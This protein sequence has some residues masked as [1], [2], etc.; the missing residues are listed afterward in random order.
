MYGEHVWEMVQ[1]N[2]T[3]TLDDF[4]RLLELTKKRNE[5]YLISWEYSLDYQEII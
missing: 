3:F 1:Q 4:I 2:R 5:K